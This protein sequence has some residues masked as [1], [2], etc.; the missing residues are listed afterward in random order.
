MTGACPDYPE[1]LPF[2]R[3]LI[4]DEGPAC[5]GLCHMDVQSGADRLGYVQQLVEQAG[6]LLRLLPPIVEA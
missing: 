1:L 6:M 3:S 4:A 5:N 2:Q